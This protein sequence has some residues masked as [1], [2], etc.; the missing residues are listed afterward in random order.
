MRL[1]VLVQPIA[2]GMP[3]GIEYDGD[4]S[5]DMFLQQLCQHVGEAKH[6]I[7]RGAIWPAHRRQRVEGAE[8]KARPVNQ[9]QVQ[10]LNCN[11]G[12]G[13]P[14][15]VNVRWRNPLLGSGHRDTSNTGT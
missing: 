13:L 5:A 8:N 2:E 3:A 12:R 1:V 4:V 7:D 6:G 14:G 9:D 10:S 15:D 11:L